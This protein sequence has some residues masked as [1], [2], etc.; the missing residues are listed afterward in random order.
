MD[1]PWLS[2]DL[3]IP[4]VLIFVHQ[5]AQPVGQLYFLLNSNVDCWK[6]SKFLR[7]VT[8][9]NGCLQ[10][11]LGHDL[12]RSVKHIEYRI[13]SLILTLLEY[14]SLAYN[15]WTGHFFLDKQHISSS[16]RTWSAARTSPGIASTAIHFIFSFLLISVHIVKINHHL[17]KKAMD[18]INKFESEIDSNYE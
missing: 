17:Q 13:C 14:G 18:I 10:N 2:L 9:Q 3:P 16:R 15:F 11:K 6:Y 4:M 7:I 12:K 1:V 5:G 8:R